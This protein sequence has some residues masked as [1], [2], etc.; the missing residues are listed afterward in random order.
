MSRACVIFALFAL[1]MILG[2][3]SG[4]F[5]SNGQKATDTAI[6][7]PTSPPPQT[8]T[9]SDQEV[10]GIIQAYLENRIIS[11]RHSNVEFRDPQVNPV[12]GLPLMSIPNVRTS[13][14]N[15]DCRSRALEIM[16]KWEARQID[17]G[18][19]AVLAHKTESQGESETTWEWRLFPSG[20]ITTI[21]G[22]C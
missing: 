4:E 21:K 1:T 15:V 3:T 22:P 19:W 12:T 17:D 18:V 13:F 9:I 20:V 16:D 11:V 8:P 5:A 2:C 6:P 10:I 14:R 7:N